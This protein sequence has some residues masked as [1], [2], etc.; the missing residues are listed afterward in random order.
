MEAI[1]YATIMGRIGALV[2]F[3]SRNDMDFYTHLEMYMRQEKPP[4]LGRDH[5]SYRS[6]FIPVKNVADGDLCEQFALLPAEKQ[7]SVAEDLD[8]TP[9]EVLKKLED[10]RNRL[11]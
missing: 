4:L 1:V 8:L 7:K 2:P 10:F 11:L 5:L 9:T 3:A 6:S